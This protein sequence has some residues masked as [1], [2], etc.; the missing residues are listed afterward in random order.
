MPQFLK[1]WIRSHRHKKIIKTIEIPSQGDILDISCSDGQ[2]FKRLHVVAPNLKL[3][4]ID[5]SNDDIEKAK[6][7]LPFADFSL[8][9]AEKINFQNQA[10]DFVF[11]IM[12]LHHYENPQKV[13]KEVQRVL[14]TNGILYLADLIPKSN[15]T[16]KI[17]NWYGCYEPYHFEKYYSI[18]DLETILKSL[19]FGLVS[20]KK[21]SLIP[22]VRILKFKKD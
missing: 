13:F 16:Q 10:F 11:L 14:K 17:L 1:N 8:Q 2:F 21:I 7:D 15:L 22:R 3:F 9:S 19:G 6:K 18:N 5:V 4:G 20:D 12:S